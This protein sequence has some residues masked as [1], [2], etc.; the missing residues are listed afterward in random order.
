[1][2][3]AER[4]KIWFNL[5][6]D[7]RG[8]FFKPLFYAAGLRGLLKSLL[9]GE[10]VALPENKADGDILNLLIALQPTWYHGGQTSF[11]DVLERLRSRQGLPLPHRLRFIRSGGAPLSESV[12]QQVEEAFGVPVLE[13][14]ALSEA[15]FVATN[16]LAPEHR[17]SGTV[18]RPWPNEM[19]IR[20]EDGHLLPPGTAAKS[21]CAARG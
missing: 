19:A 21:L 20:T 18:G 16:Y 13:A 4:R 5:T 9:L 15:G 3:T 12:R 7:D 2:V 11:M 17:K 8:L 1:M 6:P 10:S 14:Y